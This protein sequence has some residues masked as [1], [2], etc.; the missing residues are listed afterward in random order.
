M[1]GTRS[2]PGI[3]MDEKLQALFARLGLDKAET[4]QEP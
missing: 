1:E 4:D 3:V 2:L